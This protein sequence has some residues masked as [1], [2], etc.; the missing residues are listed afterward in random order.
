[1]WS[2]DRQGGWRTSDPVN[3]AHFESTL[4]EEMD[5]C[6]CDPKAFAPAHTHSWVHDLN[7]VRTAITYHCRSW[8]R[9]YNPQTRQWEGNKHCTCDYCF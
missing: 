8:S 3:V 9:W 2:R 6:G 4:K 1:M 5:K 7:G